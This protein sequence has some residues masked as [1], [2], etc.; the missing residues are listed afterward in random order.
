MEIRI[1]VRVPPATLP[2]PM[3]HDIRTTVRSSYSPKIF[4][5]VMTRS[6]RVGISDQ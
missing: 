2:T 6:C 3:Q 4:K 5:S 1:D